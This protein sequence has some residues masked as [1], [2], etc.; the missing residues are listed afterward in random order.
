MTLLN[1]FAL[2]GAIT[3]LAASPGPGVFAVTARALANSFS[4]GALV[5][6]GCVLGDLIFLLMAIYG[7]SAIA[8][9]MGNVFI[10]IK[11]I[12]ALYLIYLG[13]KILHTNEG[14]HKIKSPEKGS[15][16]ASFM[17]GFFITLGNPKVILFYLSFLPTFVDLQN[18]TNKDLLIVV[19]IVSIVLGSVL[20][21]YAWLAHR[22][23]KLFTSP[24]ALRRV[25]IAA[26]STMIGA[27]GF[28]F[29]K[30]A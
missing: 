5:A 16:K 29:V 25:D 3:L 28:L 13:V 1:I 26:G 17:S 20:M 4:H 15:F 21:T 9:L 11:Y 2:I 22:A 30:S 24:K 8:L 27:G 6:L 14:E 18:L 10:I 7:L 23:K 19:S 12:G